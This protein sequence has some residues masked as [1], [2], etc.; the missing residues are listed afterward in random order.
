MA[1]DQVSSTCQAYPDDD[2]NRVATSG[3]FLTETN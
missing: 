1:L 2:Q 3:L